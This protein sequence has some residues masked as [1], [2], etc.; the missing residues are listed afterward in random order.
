[1]KYI[2][3]LFGLILTI[4][5]TYLLIQG[6]DLF[7]I[8]EIFSNI[9]YRWL[10]AS[11]ICFLLGFFIRMSRWWL[12]LRTVQSGIKYQA[13]ILPFFISFG[14]NN[15]LPL[16]AGDIFRVFG[17]KKF[18]QCPSSKIAGTLVVERMLDLL[19]LLFYLFLALQFFTG[20]NESYQVILLPFRFAIFSGILFILILILFPQV[21]EN[22]VVRIKELNFLKSY[23]FINHCLNWVISVIQSIMICKQLALMSAL[24]LLSFFG[25][26]FE[27]LVFVIV[28]LSVNS[29]ITINSALMGFSLG[30]LS[31]LLPST[32]GYF[33]IF[34]YFAA[35]GMEITGIEVNTSVAIAVISHLVIW[36]PVT[37]VTLGYYLSH[38]KWHPVKK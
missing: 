8:Q 16:R 35:K 30:T 11:I 6:L 26:A 36:G 22:I 33:G 27:C 37:L 1:M 17:T 25:W 12:M 3:I 23:Q 24:L 18:I 28:A 13:C 15:L 21:I 19:M 2:N 5:F 7:S 10:F 38:P 29:Y 14:L 9:Q 32:P 20:N 4:I 31:T 34:D